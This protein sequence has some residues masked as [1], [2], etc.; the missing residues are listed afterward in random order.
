MKK[1]SY[2][3]IIILISSLVLAGCSLLSNIGQAPATDQSGITYLTK[4]TEDAPF[5]T[6]LFAGQNIDVG[7]VSVWND[8]TNLYVTYS[9]TDGWEMT[10]THL[11][12]A[13]SLGGIP[14][15]K[16]FNPIPGKFP[17]STIHGPAVTEFTYTVP[18]AGLGTNLYIA[19]HAKVVSPIEGCYETVWQIGDVEVDDGTG[20]LTNYCDE[21]NYAGFYEGV[22]P[23]N[24]PFTN[25]FV[26]GTTLTEDFPWLSL[27]VS[28]GPYAT[29]FK[30]QWSGELP[31][32][33]KLIVS[34][35]PGQSATETKI[36][37]SIDDG[38]PFTF[39]EI[40]SF[41]PNGWRGYPLVQSDL[42]LNPIG[43]GSH[44]ISFQHTTGD[45][46]IWDWIR[47]EKPCIQE[48]TAWANGEDFTGANWAT[49]FEYHVQGWEL[50]ETIEVPAIGTKMPSTNS[51]VG[52]HLYK[53]EA[54]GTCNWRIPP[55]SS[56][57]LADAEYWLR[58]D[59][60]GEGWTHMG[61]WSLAMWNGAPVEVE[62][63]TYN[64]AHEYT[65]K[66]TPS[67]NGQ[68]TFFFNDDGYSDNS[69]SLIVKIYEWK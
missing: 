61:I 31:F 37:T 54:S 50:L 51:L 19:A 10:E 42:E 60:Y 30:V 53:F 34:W 47:L 8:G 40:G 48:E 27:V 64:D 52:G 56:G 36:I 6:P 49:Y 3:I 29:D 20:H 55:S 44:E 12:V 23:I 21:F 41:D 67:A 68:V 2:L 28:P 11:A 38:V 5:T 39:V 9:T 62:W 16:T 26:V 63:G 65:F 35:S 22:G 57:Y 33:G 69:G 46:A 18:L 15:T 17:Y 43:G 13:N 58:H 45:G 25:P 4:H 59:A 7:T 66:Y 1:Y 24:P 14:Q 32:G